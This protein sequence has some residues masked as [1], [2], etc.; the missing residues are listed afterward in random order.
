MMSDNSLVVTR[1]DI[2]RRGLFGCCPNCGQRSL[3]QSWFRLR[4]SCGNCEMTL[5]K[6]SGFYSG[7]TSIGYVA[8]ILFIILPLCFLVT[9]KIVSVTTAI[10]LGIL[11]TFLLMLGLYPLMLCWM[12]MAYFVALPEELP[13][14][15]T[16]THPR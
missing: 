14:N 9:F 11:G 10:L 5:A 16:S 7:T 2:L 6:S 1:I 3:L 4:P 12:V 15:Q 8:S 13:A